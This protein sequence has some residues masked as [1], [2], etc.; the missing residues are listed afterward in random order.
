[1]GSSRVRLEGIPVR[2]VRKSLGWATMFRRTSALP[3]LLAVF[4]AAP[5]ALG[6]FSSGAG[7]QGNTGNT[8]ATTTTVPPATTTT[9]AVPPTT[10]TT[11]STTSAPTTTTTHP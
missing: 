8:G 9:T 3:G 11:T 6:V 2:A 10:A 5:L 7:A 1:M 4:A